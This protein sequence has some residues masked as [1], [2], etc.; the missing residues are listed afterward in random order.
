MI[1]QLKTIN[2]IKVQ[3]TDNENKIL[4]QDDVITYKVLNRSLCEMKNVI[5]NSKLL[6]PDLFYTEYCHIYKKLHEDIFKE[7]NI[8]HDITIM[9]SNFVGIEFMK[10]YGHYYDLL[11][12]HYYS[13]P[14]I[15]EILHGTALI[16]LQKPKIVSKGF[17][18][19]QG[20]DD[21]T[22]FSSITDVYIFKLNK[23]NMILI[24]PNFGRIIINQKASPLVYTSL[25][26]TKARALYQHILKYKGA[27]YYII[28]KNAKQVFVQNPNY[29]TVPKVKKIKKWPY[30]N[31]LDTKIPL[32]Q[33]FISNPQKYDWLNNPETVEWEK[34]A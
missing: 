34:F 8:R 15:I 30:A 1:I 22:D 10:T 23:G 5:L 26:S 3:Y 9:S 25:K 4:C 16:L 2:G 19:G 6:Y 33:S 14:E 18:I 21:I 7:S 29:K 17:A 32:Y 11:N 12:S 13:A 24:P 27:A 28:K 31:L 20:I